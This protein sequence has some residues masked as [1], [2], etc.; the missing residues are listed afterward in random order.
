MG[1]LPISREEEPTASANKAACSRRAVSAASRGSAIY[2]FDVTNAT[3][4]FKHNGEKRIPRLGQPPLRVKP[5]S[6]PRGQHRVIANIYPTAHR[7]DALKQLGT[8]PDEPKPKPRR[9]RSVEAASE[10]ERRTRS[11][12]QG[13][14]APLGPRVPRRSRSRGDDEVPHPAIPLPEHIP[15]S[16]GDVAATGCARR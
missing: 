15:A 1:W 4:R 11:Y 5:A 10:T 14:G 16:H 6:L 12:G 13:R 2:Y 3:D 9:R 7:A 8:H